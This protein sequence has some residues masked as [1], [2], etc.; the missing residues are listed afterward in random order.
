MTTNLSIGRGNRVKRWLSFTLLAAVLSGCDALVGYEERDVLPPDQLT[1]PAGAA[2]IFAGAVRDFGAAF[3]G[4]GGGIEGQV[5]TSG[6]MADEWILG[7]TFNT[8]LDYDSRNTLL[9]NSTLLGVFRALQTARL[10][11][12]R[13]INA[14]L[15]AEFT[16][17]DDARFGRMYNRIAMVFLMAAQNY[18]SGIPFSRE[19]NGQI[20]GGLQLTTAEMLDSA[21]FYFDKAL[22]SAAGDANLNHDFARMGKARVLLHRG[23]ASF[24]Q[25]AALV[26]GVATSLRVINE[27][28]TANNINENGIFVFNTQNRR[29]VLAHNEGTNGLPF[30]GAGAGTDPAQADPR[31]PWVQRAAPNDVAFDGELPMYDLRTYTARDNPSVIFKGEEARLIEA[32]AAL[33]GGDVAT[34]LARLNALRAGVTGLAPLA[35]PG[36]AAGRVDLLFRERAFWTFATSTRLGDMRRLIRQYGRAA[37]T[38]FPIGTYHR[39]GNY[40]PDVNFPVPDQERQNPNYSDGIACLDRNA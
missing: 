27:H 29:W 18:C 33:Q 11:A 38:V 5:M 13:A 19:E 15:A 23:P 20:I 21:D 4:N 9:D 28:S 40:G 7:D 12:H 3:A 6:M 26:A 31:V 22:A 39:G 16:E 30:R 32:E 25:A 34:F 10:G 14:L 24:A 1:G 2:A 35:D 17:A 8:R 37:N 36:T